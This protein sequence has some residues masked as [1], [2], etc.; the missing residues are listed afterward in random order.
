[1]ADLANAP[2]R[3]CLIDIFEHGKS[4][5]TIHAKAGTFS[6]S[7]KYIR[8]NFFTCPFVSTLFCFLQGVV[9]MVPWLIN[10]YTKGHLCLLKHFLTDSHQGGIRKG[11]EGKLSKSPPAATSPTQSI[12]MGGIENQD[13]W[14]WKYQISVWQRKKTLGERKFHFQFLIWQ[15]QNSIFLSGNFEAKLEPTLPRTANS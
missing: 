6:K 2:R 13:S 11:V 9:Q 8:Y 5:Q 1:M 12:W 7:K 10:H 3:R 14:I 4:V 15:T